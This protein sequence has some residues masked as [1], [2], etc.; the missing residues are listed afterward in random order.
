MSDGSTHIEFADIDGLANGFPSVAAKIAKDKDKTTNIFR[1]FDR[2]AARNLLYLQSR[3]QKLE[4]ELD[5]YDAEDFHEGDMLA[6]RSLTS[7][8]DFEANA[9]NRDWEKKRMDLAMDIQIALRN[10]RQWE[11]VKRC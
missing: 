7:W 10:Y 4:S 5:R 11:Q 6:K 9:N 8:E 3:L 2:L 1:R